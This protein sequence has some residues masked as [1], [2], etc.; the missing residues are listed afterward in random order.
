MGQK[1]G[2]RAAKVK[3]RKSFKMKRM[4]N[5]VEYLGMLMKTG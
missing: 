3:G 4:I 5:S 1:A 2:K